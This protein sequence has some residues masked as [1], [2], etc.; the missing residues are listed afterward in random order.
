M[1]CPF[2]T[3]TTTQTN[4]RNNYNET[5]R[6]D[7]QEFCKCDPNCM[8]YTSKP[9]RGVPCLKI[10]NEFGLIEPLDKTPLK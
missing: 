1:N 9:I 3:K 2:K 7:Y 4:N 10:I 5:V 6:T 8:Y